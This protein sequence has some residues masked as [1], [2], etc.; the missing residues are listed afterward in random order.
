MTKE[1]KS[2]LTWLIIALVLIGTFLVII[3]AN[4]SG[5]GTTNVLG[6]E[7]ADGEWIKGN[8]DAKVTLV[9]YSDFQCPA[10]KSRETIVKS[11]IGEF[12]NHIKF[13]YRHF[14][15]QS[16]H[17]NAHLAARA[18]EAAGIQ[19]KF[20]EMHD[21]IFN[22]QETWEG[23]SNASAEEL[24]TSYAE[25][26]GLDIDKFSSDIDSSE[27]RDAVDADY[28]SGEEA[29]V[30]GTPTFFLNGKEIKPNSYEDYRALI[31]TA[32]EQAE[33]K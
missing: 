19:G 5:N 25:E 6:T 15:L 32:I 13:V 7:V 21:A 33:S 2:I 1:S 17:A 12:G 20:W 18:S 9:E 30:A 26:L 4:Q 3:F 31:R 11:L 27:V 23:L 10:C 24:F 8:P 29:K 28:A 14:P 22:N 16:I